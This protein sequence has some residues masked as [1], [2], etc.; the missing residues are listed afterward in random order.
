MS[1]EPHLGPLP[2][3][4]HHLKTLDE[5]YIQFFQERYIRRIHLL[6]RVPLTL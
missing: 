3:F 1:S 6:R 2:Y 4:D 5:S